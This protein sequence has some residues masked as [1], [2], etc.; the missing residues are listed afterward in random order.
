VKQKTREVFELVNEFR[1]EL[2]WVAFNGMFLTL[3]ASWWAAI[4]HVA[5]VAFFGMRIGVLLHKNHG[6]SANIYINGVHMRPGLESIHVDG[7]PGPRA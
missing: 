6:L 7:A 4:V 2:F 5:L 1:E 3:G